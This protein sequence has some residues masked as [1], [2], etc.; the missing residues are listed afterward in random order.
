MVHQEL[1][2]IR[3]RSIA[4][5]IYCG[6]YPLKSLGPIK[7]VDHKKMNADAKKYLDEVGLK[8]EPTTKL[9]NLTVNLAHSILPKQEKQNQ[10]A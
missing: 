3:D 8:F 9:G 6:R 2:P 1:M 10:F 5:N 7:V 4:E